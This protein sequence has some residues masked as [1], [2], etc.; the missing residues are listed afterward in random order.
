MAKISTTLFGEK[1]F[2]PYQA[3]TPILE[4]FEFLTDVIEHQDG[5][6]Q[7]IQ[8]RQVAR[9][10]FEYTI[11]LQYWKKAAAFNTL[12]GAL[13]KDWAVPVWSEGQ[14]VG[15]ITAAQTVI[16]CDT[17]VHDL[18]AS[19]LAMLFSADGSYE[20]VEIDTI[21]NTDVTL[22]SGASARLSA[23]L[24]PVKTAF[25]VGTATLSSSGREG[26][27]KLTFQ[28]ENTTE[29]TSAAPSQYLGDDIYYEPGILGDSKFIERVLEMRHDINDFDLGIVG[30]ST[31]WLNPRYS[32]P[33]R[34]LMEG[35]TEVRQYKE[36]VFRRAGK[37]RAFWLPTFENDLRHKSA[38]LVTNILLVD[39]DSIV[40][41]ASNRVHIAVEDMAGNWY[42]RQVTEFQQTGSTTVQ[43][44]LDSPLNIDASEIARISYLGLNRMDI[45]RVELNWLGNSVVRSEVR[46]VE[47]SP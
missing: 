33:Y 6:E 45:E 10:F 40:D 31:P 43:I 19:S 25:I 39:S 20:I 16:S 5:T 38:N 14:F 11:P 30:R 47:L 35:A 27:V 32:M 36:W 22:L 34:A 24:I 13:R 21:T 28:I 12:Y 4:R 41:Y 46:I 1:A 7:R 2:L 42:P 3:E 44:T 9:Q 18:T 37:Y 23:Y 29:I 8:T 15:D 17:L 26:S